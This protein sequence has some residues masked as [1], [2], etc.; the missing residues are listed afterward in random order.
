MF[1]TRIENL[2]RGSH[3]IEP[4]VWGKDG[5]HRYTYPMFLDDPVTGEPL[6]LFRSGVSSRAEIRI[7]RWN[8]STKKYRDDRAALISGRGGPRPSGPYLNTPAISRDGKITLFYVWRLPAEATDRGAVVNVGLDGICSLDGLRTVAMSNGVTISRP[9]VPVTSER[10]V[11]VPAG[12][13]L[14]NQGA[15]AV[16]ADGAPMALTYWNDQDG[17]AQYKLVWEEGGRWHVRNASKFTTRFQ[18][19]G[20]GTLPLPHS[21]PELLMTENGT[22][23]C[24]FRSQEFKNR[25][26]LR[27]L[28]PPNYGL[29]GSRT[30][31]LVDQ[32]LGFYE[33]V[34]DRATW[35]TEG[36]LSIYVQ[37]CQQTIGDYE[38]TVISTPA[39]LVEW[40]RDTVGRLVSERN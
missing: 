33:P 17:I 5:S 32:D 21:R 13:N 23:L 9:V 28:N 8:S 22:A 3:V 4:E 6:L 15:G 27:S 24:I 18:L 20:V 7:K 37:R 10:V 16:R 31:V 39:F 25:L 2:H 12:A 35:H 14:I 40:K 34:V 19:D 38:K 1:Y 26:V 30:I 36:T 29:K 11:S